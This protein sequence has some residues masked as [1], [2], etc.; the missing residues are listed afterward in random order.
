MQLVTKRKTLKTRTTNYNRITSFFAKWTPEREKKQ[1]SELI[2]SLETYLDTE[3][4]DDVRKAYE[5]GAKAHEGQ[6]RKRGEKYINHPLAVARLLAALH[7]DS[8]S[9]IAAILHDTIEDTE[10]T[11]DDLSQTFGEDIAQ[12]VEG[13][14]KVSHFEFESPEHAEVANLRRMFLAMSNDVRVILIKMADRLH[15]LESLDVHRLEKRK[16]IVRQTED[17]YIPIANLL[18]MQEWQRTMQDLCFKA[19]YPRRFKT[20]QKAIKK[21]YKGKIDE[22][23]KKHMAAIES[24]IDNQGIDA[25]VTGRFKHISAIHNKMRRKG[26]SLKAVQDM[27]ALRVVVNTVDECYRTLGIIHQRY[28]PISSEF[29]DYIAIPKRNG[30]QSLHTTVN[31]EFGQAIEV[32]IR[33]KDMHRLAETGIASHLSYKNGSR[34]NLHSDLKSADWLSDL[35]QNLENNQTPSD[36]LEHLKLSLFFD[37][38]YVFTRDGE[39]KRLRKGATVIDFAY[40]IHTEVGNKAKS[41]TINN[42]RVPFHTVLSNGDRVEIKK[43]EFSSPGPDWLQFA[44]TS[45]ARMGIRNALKV[46]ARNEMIQM[47]DRLLKKAFRK[48]QIKYSRVTEEKKQRI[49]KK[50]QVESWDQI[51]HD[52]CNGNRMASVVVNQMFPEH[53]QNVNLQSMD[54]TPVSIQ[55]TE[56]LAVSYAKCCSPIPPEPLIGFFS[57]GRGIVV[58]TEDCKNVQH[59]K[60]GSEHWSKFQW[61]NDPK[62]LFRV[63]IR[64]N[65]INKSGVLASIAT[66]IAAEKANIS[67]CDLD[68]TDKENATI[69][70][71]IE[72]NDLSHL[73]AIM[74]RIQ[75]D[76]SVFS[77][78]RLKLKG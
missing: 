38:V 53:L 71:E 47:G 17:V 77:L 43:S 59:S 45:R 55:G 76:P 24:L 33:T 29:N 68:V 60:H 64:V 11:R 28:K 54:N 35:I 31:A 13:V 34:N 12:M 25:L 51:L 40:S 10:L 62:G 20:L 48:N 7:L 22:T 65:A 56:G 23:V 19:I 15:N 75:R 41:A 74:R 5:V 2:D 32:Q 27:M 73:D 36:Y 49:V 72:V 66:R 57:L 69:E 21:E 9:I 52:I 78:K 63:S 46:K 39:I 42:Q 50:L 14:S 18:G 70:F 16:R 58:H 37:D 8:R 26:N 44:A 61:T 67:A 4:I 3:Q 1:F 30:Y 6:R